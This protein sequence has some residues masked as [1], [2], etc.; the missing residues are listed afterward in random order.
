[1]HD[2]G[3]QT[4]TAGVYNDPSSLAV[5]GTVTLDGSGNPDSVFIFCPFW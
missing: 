3:G 5:T 1:V 2:L 4:F